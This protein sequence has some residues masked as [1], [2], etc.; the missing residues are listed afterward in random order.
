MLSVVKGRCWFLYTTMLACAISTILP[1]PSTV[2]DG[3][4]VL[5]GSA[6][7][8]G[9]GGA[10][11]PPRLQG[12]CEGASHCPGVLSSGQNVRPA[13]PGQSHEPSARVGVGARFSPCT[14]MASVT[15]RTSAVAAAAAGLVACV[16]CATASTRTLASNAAILARVE[17]THWG[18]ES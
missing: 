10:Q 7:G 4:M 15:K 6:P 9:G 1:S 8:C 5:I 13:C 18:D 2:I 3:F 12:L 11:W 14:W 16:V 17:S